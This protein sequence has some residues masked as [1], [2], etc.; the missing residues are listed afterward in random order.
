MGDQILHTGALFY[1][2]AGIPFFFGVT[3]A[4]I[5]DPVLFVLWFIMTMLLVL[6]MLAG[7]LA[8]ERAKEALSREVYT[9][10]YKEIQR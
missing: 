8:L 9:D 1:V 5:R 6:G 4:T 3:G 10:I 7:I 2:A